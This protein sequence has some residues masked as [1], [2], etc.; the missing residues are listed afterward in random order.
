MELG[1]ETRNERKTMTL[2]EF[3]AEAKRRNMRMLGTPEEV[4]AALDAKDAEIAKLRELL[5]EV[6]DQARHP[7]YD[8]PLCLCKDV[9]NALGPN[10]EVSR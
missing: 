5:S 6:S 9:A 1:P 8:W 2:D 10:V 3:F 7:D 4:R